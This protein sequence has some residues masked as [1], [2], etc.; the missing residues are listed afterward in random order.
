PK[1]PGRQAAGSQVRESW[2][3]RAGRGVLECGNR[4]V[5]QDTERY[6]VVA[7]PVRPPSYHVSDLENLPRVW[8][9]DPDW[10]GG[11]PELRRQNR[12]CLFRVGAGS[13]RVVGQGGTSPAG[14]GAHIDSQ[15]YRKGARTREPLCNSLFDQLLPAARLR[16][17]SG[18]HLYG[19]QVNPDDEEV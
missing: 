19:F 2:A 16:H 15:R 11:V 9:A 17:G 12:H 18:S 10:P 8:D 14:P 7:P 3:G 13:H 6:S 5:L 4:L 1:R